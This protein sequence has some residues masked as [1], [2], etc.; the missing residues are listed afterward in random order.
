MNFSSFFCMYMFWLSIFTYCLTPCLLWYL[1][2]FAEENI[3]LWKRTII[4]NSNEE[5]LFI[6]DVIASFAK[7]DTS[8]ILEIH[9]LEKVVTDF[10]NIVESVWMKNLKIV[11]ITKYSKSWWN[12]NCNKD[13]EKYRSLKNIEDWKTF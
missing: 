5:D 13:L 4:K 3:N 7:L 1:K 11:N 9:Q 8:N 10:A 12:D 2:I 6:K